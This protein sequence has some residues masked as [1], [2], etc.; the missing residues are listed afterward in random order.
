MR[1]QNRQT[2]NGN[3]LYIESIMTKSEIRLKEFSFLFLA[4]YSFL[5]GVVC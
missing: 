4:V 1:N 2:N 5:S 3:F